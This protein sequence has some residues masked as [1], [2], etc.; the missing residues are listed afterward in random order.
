MKRIDPTTQPDANSP[1]PAA[2]PRELDP[3]KLRNLTEPEKR[4][5]LIEGIFRA[6]AGC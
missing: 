4:Q 3:Q 5:H 2:I 1:E 6:L